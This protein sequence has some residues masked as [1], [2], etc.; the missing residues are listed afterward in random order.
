MSEEPRIYCDDEDVIHDY[1]WKQKR[2]EQKRPAKPIGISCR[3]VDT[4]SRSMVTVLLDEIILVNDKPG[5]IR[6]LQK[7]ITQSLANI[8]NE[9]TEKSGQAGL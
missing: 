9:Y 4:S 3:L 5:I 6:N 2:K 7:D 1:I 8:L